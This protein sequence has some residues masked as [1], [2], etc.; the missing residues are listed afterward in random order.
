MKKQVT[1]TL[2]YLAGKDRMH[3]IANYFGTGKSTALKFIRRVT[4]AMSSSSYVSPTNK[5]D[6]EDM[7]SNFYN[8]HDFPQCIVRVNGTHVG[9]KRSSLN[10]SYFI[11]KKGK[12]TLNIQQITT[13][14]FSAW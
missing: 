12:C 7:T 8:S 9:V 10:T 13:T 1:T 11:Y 2:H 14:A 5:N 6:I 3:K 4:Q